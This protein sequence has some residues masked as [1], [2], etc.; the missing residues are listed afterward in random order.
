MVN[1]SVIT[2]TRQ[3]G[4]LG[5]V[6]AR[7][8]AE[9]LGYDYYDREIIEK[10]AEEMGLPVNELS[11]FENKKLSAFDK[12]MYPLGLGTARKKAD[13]F[14]VE[15]KIIIDLAKKGNCVIV[16]RC[17]DFILKEAG[18]E[19][20]L[21]VYVYAPY[22][23]RRLFCMNDLG[24]DLEQSE[25]YLECVDEARKRFYKNQ[26]GHSFESILYRHLLI[27]SSAF[28]LLGSV[29][30]ITEAARIKFSL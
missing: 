20:V 14:D 27:D 12:M 2:V 22:S 26:T 18:F 3:F 25:K 23:K 7:K 19:N 5:R 11:E 8:V 10:V 1:Q 16:G 24:L 28:T 15:K 17:A 9:E 4:S 30:L 21:N 29:Q 6:I 13:I